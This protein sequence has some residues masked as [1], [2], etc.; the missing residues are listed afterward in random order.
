MIASAA[1]GVAI[2]SALAA[3]SAGTAQKAA[4]AIAE[5]G[6]TTWTTH[7][8]STSASVGHPLSDLLTYQPDLVPV[9]AE[10]A[11]LRNVAVMAPVSQS[12]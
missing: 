5:G 1:V 6:V 8:I 7:G 11:W 9:G 2:L 12:L 3:S 10:V 4:L